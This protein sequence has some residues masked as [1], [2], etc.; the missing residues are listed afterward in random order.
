VKVNFCPGS[1]FVG[2]ERINIW[3]SPDREA[4]AVWKLAKKTSDERTSI[5][6][7]AGT[8]V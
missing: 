1:A 7:I 4:D 8:M 3:N 2:A 5:T 6:I